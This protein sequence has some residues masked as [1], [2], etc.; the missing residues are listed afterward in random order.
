MYTKLESQCD[1]AKVQSEYNHKQNLN[2]QRGSSHLDSPS[3]KM[4]RL[5]VD[6]GDYNHKG[7]SPQRKAKKNHGRNVSS[8]M[9]TDHRVVSDT[10]D[11]DKKHAAEPLKES[12]LETNN[13]VGMR[14]SKETRE[15]SRVLK[16]VGSTQS[17]GR[18]L[19]SIP[20]T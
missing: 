1:E 17:L 14:S 15:T 19:I 7:N 9:A 13:T 6:D 5:S 4:F 11:M 8:T 12:Q 18:N 16:M 3:S 2:R 10:E 20:D